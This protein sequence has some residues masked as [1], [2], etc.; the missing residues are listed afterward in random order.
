MATK[1]LSVDTSTGAEAW[2]DIAPTP[3]APLVLPAY[4]ALAAGD[5][6]SIYV[7][8]STTKVRKAV[9][10]AS[11]YQAHGFVLLPVVNPGDNATVYQSGLNTAVVASLT[12]GVDYF[13]S[14]TGGTSR[15]TTADPNFTQYVGYATAVHTLNF[16]P[17]QGVAVV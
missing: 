2:V 4:E 3:S 13:L 7:D 12:P 15:A 1:Y 17:S 5:L 8:G 9:A 14:A 10:G 16:I 6:V 11:P